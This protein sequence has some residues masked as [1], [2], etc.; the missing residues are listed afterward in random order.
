[1]RTDRQSGI[2][3]IKT[4]GKFRSLYLLWQKKKGMFKI[5]VKFQ[6][7]LGLLWSRKYF[8]F[9]HKLITHCSVAWVARWA[10]HAMKRQICVSYNP[11]SLLRLRWSNASSLQEKN[12]TVDPLH[13]QRNVIIAD[14][15]VA[16]IITHVV[17]CV[18]V[19]AASKAK[20]ALG[21]CRF[22]PDCC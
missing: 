15:I 5:P 9:P 12:S 13:A 17:H 4:P 1:M 18:S 19:R 11:F 2:K 6:N 10:R 21:R 7:R 16:H 22:G 3:H 14:V 8:I 20:D